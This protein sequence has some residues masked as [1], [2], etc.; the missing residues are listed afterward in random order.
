MQQTT[1]LLC[2]R[3]RPPEGDAAF[4]SQP[5]K[6][7]WEPPSRS[8]RR[9]NDDGNP[10]E[11]A[12]PAAEKNTETGEAEDEY[13]DEEANFRDAG[14]PENNL[15]EK[16]MTARCDA[17]TLPRRRT[18]GRCVHKFPERLP[19]LTVPVAATMRRKPFNNGGGSAKGR[20]G[21]G[22]GRV[23]E[24][25]ALRRSGSSCRS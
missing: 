7:E 16:Y 21:G 10:G 2:K 23:R 11:V 15:A 24:R 1:S 19:Q 20:G 8:R 14:G 4:S 22:K 5:Q 13:D 18:G 6:E 17:D 3:T 25:R 9:R 12:E